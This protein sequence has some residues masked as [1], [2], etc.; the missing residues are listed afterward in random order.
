[1]FAGSGSNTAG[2]FMAFNAKTGEELWRVSRDGWV[3]LST[4]VYPS[5]KNS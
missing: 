3:L 2:Y 5:S 4:W 1:M